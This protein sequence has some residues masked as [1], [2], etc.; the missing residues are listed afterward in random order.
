MSTRK[1]I[2]KK[3]QT[4]FKSD[5]FA[6]VAM[7]SLMLNLFLVVG[8]VLFFSTN[9]LDRPA[10]RAAYANLCGENYNA[11]LRNQ[12]GYDQSPAEAKAVFNAYCR[13]GDFVDYFDEAVNNYL[14]DK[15]YDAN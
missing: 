11:N 6:A 4:I 2:S 8:I 14:V 1:K 3:A 15:G 10:Y 7:V 12:P 5:M 9:R 13:T